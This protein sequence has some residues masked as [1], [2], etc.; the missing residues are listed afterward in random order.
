MKRT[1]PDGWSWFALAGA[2]NYARERPD[3][4]IA[5]AESAGSCCHGIPT[6]SGSGRRRWPITPRGAVK[7]SR[8]STRLAPAEE[9]SRTPRV[10]GL[11]ALLAVARHAAKRRH[12]RGRPRD[13][14]GGTESR[15]SQSQRLVPARQLPD[16][17]T[18]KRRGLPAAEEG[19]RALAPLNRGASGVLE[20]VE[21]QPRA[22]R[23]EEAPG[24]RGGCRSSSFERM[25]TVP[26]PSSPWRQ[27]SKQMKWGDRQASCEKTILTT[28]RDSREAEW[29]LSGRW[30]DLSATLEGA[31]IARVSPDTHRLRGAAAP[32]PK[33][34]AAWRGVS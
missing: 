32:L 20:S 2:L 27:V 12:V 17:R 24:D 28:F 19:D 23:G 11:R 29:V 22:R 16:R 13:V 31:R 1:K 7:R 30:R 33:S 4:A 14:R 5:A 6:S 21:R 10:E 15:S 26:E 9:P 34:T 25:A 18:S 3:E 8:L